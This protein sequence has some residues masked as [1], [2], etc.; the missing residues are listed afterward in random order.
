MIK[1]NPI[2]WFY[3][4]LPEAQ[5]VEEKFKNIISKNYSLSGFTPMETP[6][7]ERV[8]TLTSKWW[9]DS[10][11]YGVHRLKWEL[12]DTV[13]LWLRFDLTVPFARYVAQYEWELNFPFKRQQIQKVFRWERPQ[14]WR[15]REFYQADIDIVWN[16]KLALFADVEI[17]STLYN[18]LSE[19]SFWDFV[20][21]INNKKLLIWFLES[22]W[23]EKIGETIAIIDKKD[24]VKTIVPMLEN[25]WLEEKIVNNILELIKVSEE[26]SSL[27]LLKYF[28]NIQN[29]SL[30]E[31][32][33][34]L[35]YVYSN[36]LDLWVAEKSIKI[37]PAISRGLNYYTWTVFEI[38]ITGHE[39]FWSISSG[40][41]YE[42]L[43]SN[44]TKNNYPW[45]GGSIWLSRLLF[46][47]N[48]IWKVEK[49]KKTITDV[50]VVNMWWELLKDALCLVKNLRW[51]W[52]NT[53]LFLD[54]ETK[55][56]K[57]LKYANNKMIPFVIIMGE[58]EREKGIVQLKKLET[59]EQFEVKI[60]EVVEKIKNK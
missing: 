43:C 14:K 50:L 1:Q 46:V 21:H 13:T 23:V 59:W 31:W 28:K 24:K 40:W 32:L 38:F 58:E 48:E 15:F 42:N 20:I 37:N 47:L 10:E 57:Q 25:L 34:E 18:A 55:I 16:G 2:S 53:E 33:K 4:N 11:I 56:A 22:I 6:C 7:I 29:D 26:G 44:F 30:Q 36:L 49:N 5:I 51:K 12:W 41:R 52:I 60:N 39:N 17:L 8:E 9:D 3:E 35:N 19:L 45:V 54:D 27:E